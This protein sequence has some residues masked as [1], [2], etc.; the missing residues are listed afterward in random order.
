M[1]EVETIVK[2]MLSG[3]LNFFWWVG[4][5]MLKMKLKLLNFLTKLK[6][7]LKLKFG[8][9]KITV[10]IVATNVIASASQLSM[11]ASLTLVPKD[12]LLTLRQKTLLINLGL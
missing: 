12:I 5:W 4:G 1:T 10:E 6:S 7:K 8:K 3:L 2:L 9:K 11:P